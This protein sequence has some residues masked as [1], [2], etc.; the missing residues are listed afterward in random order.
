MFESTIEETDIN[1]SI[2]TVDKIAGG[3]AVHDNTAGAI[4]ADRDKIAEEVAEF[5]A[6]Q[7][8][9]ATLDN[10]VDPS[11]EWAVDRVGEEAHEIIVID[12][13][14]ETI[15]EKIAEEASDD[16]TIDP[17]IELAVDRV[18]EEANEIIVIDSITE[19]IIDK[20]AEEV[21]EFLVEQPTEAII[22][23]FAGDKAINDNTID[24]SIELAVLEAAEL[25]VDTSIEAILVAEE[26]VDEFSVDP[27]IEAIQSR[28]TT[29]KEAEGP[30]FESSQSALRHTIVYRLSE[31]DEFEFGQ[32]I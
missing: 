9:E 21:A 10:T 8:I 18:G 25:A 22:D 24:P 19:T 17:S 23:K 6:E 32:R 26:R 12:S 1:S 4:V 28:G 15:I 7:P 13:I 5:L 29:D 16:N 27:L 31:F 3:R 20:I 11:I 30:R 2:E 14:T